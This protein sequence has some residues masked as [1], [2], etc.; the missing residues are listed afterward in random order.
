MLITKAAKAFC[1]S[2]L[3]PYFQILNLIPAHGQRHHSYSLT[4]ALWSFKYAFHATECN[5]NQD[6]K[7]KIL[8]LLLHQTKYDH[9]ANSTLSWQT[10][11]FNS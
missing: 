5:L 9:L 4:Y 1:N 3:T 7:G 6:T 8:G 2:K 10:T 11:I